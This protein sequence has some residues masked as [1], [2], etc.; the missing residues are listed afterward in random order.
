[1]SGKKAKRRRKMINEWVKMTN[2]KNC[3]FCGSELIELDCVVYMNKQ[4]CQI[5]NMNE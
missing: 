5:L 2:V 4:A 1:M 3:Q